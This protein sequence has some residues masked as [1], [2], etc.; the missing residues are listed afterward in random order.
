M[1]FQVK[2]CSAH[3]KESSKLI[4][5]VFQSHAEDPHLCLLAVNGLVTTY[6]AISWPVIWESGAQGR[7][8][9]KDQKGNEDQQDES[10]P[11]CMVHL[12]TDL[13]HF[14]ILS[15]MFLL[16]KCGTSLWVP[17]EQVTGLVAI[18]TT[19]KGATVISSFI[20]SRKIQL[21][22]KFVLQSNVTDG[23]VPVVVKI[24]IR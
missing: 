18:V 20:G 12:C 4:R 8:F 1:L 10:I 21:L 17:T 3:I 11:Q 2:T 22:C 14:C 23:L 15:V 6:Q 5:T 13:L 19:R 24:K 9:V 16:G 7:A